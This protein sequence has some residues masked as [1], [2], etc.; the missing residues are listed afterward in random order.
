MSGTSRSSQRQP[1][2]NERVA[3][4][5]EKVDRLEET[6]MAH[7][8]AMSEK[9]DMILQNQHAGALDRALLR[10]DITLVQSEISDMKPHVKTVANAKTFWEWSGK[11]GAVL[12]AIGAAG[13]GLFSWLKHYITIRW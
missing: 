13:W 3:V 8:R 5:E 9:M 11:T 4:V 7:H 6:L 2:T 10:Q 12:T 1:S